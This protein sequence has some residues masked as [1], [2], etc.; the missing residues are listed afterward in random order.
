MGK[1]SSRADRKAD[2]S[3]A[4]LGKST[5]T[6]SSSLAESVK[7]KITASRTLDVKMLKVETQNG[8]V[9]IHG[10]AKNA[11][12]KAAAGDIAKE[13]KGVKTVEN[14]IAIRP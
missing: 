14:E 4:A 8:T 11:A 5:E 13:V 10:T 6:D 3:G 1:A 7:R 12:E 9:V 2:S